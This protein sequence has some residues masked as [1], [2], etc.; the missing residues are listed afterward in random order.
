MK[1]HLVFQDLQDFWDVAFR[2]SNAYNKSSREPEE[3]WNGGL[4]WNDSKR[5]ALRGWQEGA[6]K[7]KEFQVKISP[8]ITNKIVKTVNEYGICGGYVDIGMYLANDP[9]CFVTKSYGEEIKEGKIITLVC[10]IS[11]SAKIIAETIIQR[12]AMI[13]ALVDAIEYAGFR[14]ELIC[15]DAS[16]HNCDGWF[17]IDV[18][19]KKANQPLNLIE[20]AFCLAHPA[21]LRRMMFSVAEIEGWSDYAYLY[22]CPAEATNKG[23]LYIQEIFSETVSDAEAINWVLS[24]LEKLGITIEKQQ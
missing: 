7:V 11:F 3:Y 20:M 1:K 12:G 21:M 19:L 15:N 22:G 16:K 14:V 2:E 24:E 9:E 17:E 6:Q 4:S 5:L 23:A 8:L 10:S 18:L 13:C